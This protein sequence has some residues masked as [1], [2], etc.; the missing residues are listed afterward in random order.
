MRLAQKLEVELRIVDN[1]SVVK[2]STLSPTFD[3]T[4]VLDTLKSIE[5]LTASQ[6]HRDLVP[7]PIA[8]GRSNTRIGGLCRLLGEQRHL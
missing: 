1:I 6:W 8:G 5:A 2:V 4:I 7:V 3:G